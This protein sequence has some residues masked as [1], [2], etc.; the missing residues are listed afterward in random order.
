MRSMSS[1]LIN[2]RDHVLV[3][4]C[5]RSKVAEIG[6]VWAK[7]LLKVIRHRSYIW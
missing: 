3:I 1:T 4:H 7:A 6:V 5:T 2:V